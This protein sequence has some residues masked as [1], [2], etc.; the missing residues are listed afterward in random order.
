MAEAETE[1]HV[2]DKPSHRHQSIATS[3][4]ECYEK[5]VKPLQNVVR[6]RFRIEMAEDCF[7][8]TE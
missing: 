8:A 5:A 6:L 2:G 7:A 3:D 4:P 1:P